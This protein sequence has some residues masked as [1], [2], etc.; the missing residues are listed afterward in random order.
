MPL[1]LFPGLPLVLCSGV[2]AFLSLR[3]AMHI[4]QLNSYQDFPYQNWLR[5][6]HCIKKFVHSYPEPEH[7]IFNGSNI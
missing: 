6:H 5:A 3:Q 2:C 4:F 1:P 7:P